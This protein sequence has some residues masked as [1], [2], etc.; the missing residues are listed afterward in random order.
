V[1]DGGF[2]A[3]G[4]DQDTAII[5]GAQLA[6]AEPGRGEVIDASRK[7]AEVAANQIE[8]DLVERS[9]ARGRAKNRFRRPNIFSA[10]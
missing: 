9:R 1:S 3:G 4:L 10:G 5:S 7:A 2:A 6:Q 8:L